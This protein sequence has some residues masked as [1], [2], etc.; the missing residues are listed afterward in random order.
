MKKTIVFI[1]FLFF[2][3]GCSNKEPDTSFIEIEKEE[4][5]TISPSPGGQIV[6]PITNYEEINPLYPS[7][8]YVYYFTKL[9]YD[10]LFEYNEDG[11]LET[12]IVEHYVVSPDKLSMTITIKDNIYF[13]DGEKLTT[14]DILSTFYYLINSDDNSPYFHNFINSVGYGF[15]FD[16]SNFL[17]M[18]IFDD[19][20]IDLHF[21]RPYADKLDM[22]TFPILKEGDVN[23]LLSN[24]F[25]EDNLIGT[26]AYKVDK[27]VKGNNIS[28]SMFDMYN[29][30]LPYIE[31]LNVKI[32]KDEE[33]ALLA[34]ETG[35]I[36]LVKSV[37]YD[38]AKYQDDTSIKIEEFP[39]NEM[40]MLIFNNFSSKFSG[41]KGRILKQAISKGI[42]KK[43]II[44]RLFLGKAIETSLPLTK[45]KM[46]F[47]GLKSDNYYN[48]EISKELLKEIGYSKYNES[49][50]LVDENQEPITIEITSNYADN[51]KRIITEFIIEDLKAIGINAYS[52][53]QVST[54]ENLSK[55]QI[56]GI[57]KEYV[58]KL[59]QDRF[60]MA[61][62][63][64]NLTEISDL[65]T[66][67]HSLAIDTGLNYSNYS[68]PKLDYIIN[69]LKLTDEFENRRNIYLELIDIYTEEMP[70]IPLY[71]KTS[72][73]LIDNKIQNNLNPINSDIY[74]S[75]SN[76]F[77]LKQLQ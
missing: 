3:V 67:L 24:E 59:T 21:D 46:D 15:E 56:D 27:I 36:N 29:G 31:K 74:R 8:T 66:L 12:N 13:H 23:L 7:N 54:N 75:F 11:G 6:I 1:L 2:I 57:N 32:F 34:F 42:N 71:T 53:M 22:L 41:D 19:R 33:L 73:I 35:L 43:R 69:N 63:S 70:L 58:E 20:N 45:N 64:L 55:E 26:G 10:S 68:N 37:N 44:D 60:E 72:A 16:K 28:L 52:N 47:Y 17:T 48:A 77:I 50:F 18:E 65:S 62:V 30:N 38:W 40:D 39:T 5:S 25:K 4:L 9:I 51:H 14:Q 61:I 76:V 49:G